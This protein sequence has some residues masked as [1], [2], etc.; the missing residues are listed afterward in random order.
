[1]GDGFVNLIEQIGE[2]GRVAVGM[3]VGVV[4]HSLGRGA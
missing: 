2:G 3:F 1:M 4:I